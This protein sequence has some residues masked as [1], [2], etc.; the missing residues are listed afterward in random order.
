M[1]KQEVERVKLY[2]GWEPITN[3]KRIGYLFTEATLLKAGELDFVSK[4]YYIREYDFTRPEFSIFEGTVTYP[5]FV[6]YRV[7]RYVPLEEEEVS[8]SCCVN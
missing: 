6:D 4:S 1:E 2:V 8:M 5:Y 3:K 7:E